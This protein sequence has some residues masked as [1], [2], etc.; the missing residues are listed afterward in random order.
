VAVAF[1][2]IVGLGILISGQEAPTQKTGLPDDWTHHHLVFSNPGTAAQALKEGRLEQWYK[3]TNDPRY[4]IQ[5]LKRNPLQRALAGAQDFAA[6]SAILNANAVP[7]RP[8]VSKNEPVKKDWNMDL[9]P[10]GTATLTA[11]VGTTID[12]ATLPSGSSFTIDGQTF[13][14]K[15]PTTASANG[16]FSGNPTNGQ[17]LQIKNV[18]PSITLTAST[19]TP[20]TQ[21][22]MFGAVPTEATAG[23]VIS[24]QNGANTL[25]VTNSASGANLPNSTWTN[26]PTTT[27][28]APSVTVS[29]VVTNLALA[30][31]AAAPTATATFSGPLAAGNTL[32]I[33]YGVTSLTLTAA[34]GSNSTAYVQVSGTVSNTYNIVVGAVTYAFAVASSCSGGTPSAPCIDI[35]TSTN[36]AQAQNI[37]AAINDNPNECSSTTGNPCFGDITAPNPEA[38]AGAPTNPFSTYWRIPLTNEYYQSVSFSKTGTNLGVSGSPMSQATTNGCSS[39]TL[40][41]FIIGTGQV[42]SAANLYNILTSSAACV[43]TYSV[44]VTVSGLSNNTFNVGETMYGAT[45]GVSNAFGTGAGGYTNFGWSN[46]TTGNVGSGNSCSGTTSPYTA[47][48]QAANTTAG[49]M[50][51]VV[52]AIQACP[53]GANIWAAPGTSNAFTVYNNTLAT[54]SSTISG[55]SSGTPSIV[56]WATHVSGS[57]GSNS[58]TGTTSAAFRVLST[59]TTAALVA[60]ELV[61]ALTGCATTNDGTIGIVTGSGT[62]HVANTGATVTITANQWAQNPGLALTSSPGGPFSWTASAITNGLNG[63]NTPPSFAVDNILNDDATNLAAAIAASGS[64][65]GVSA[66]TNGGAEVII[67]ASAAGL[68]GNSITLTN[69]LSSISFPTGLTGGSNGSDSSTTFAYWSG[70]TYDNQSQLA[71]DIYAAL[72]ANSTITGATGAFTVGA[73]NSPGAGDIVLTYKTAGSGGD[74][75][76]LISTFSALTGG[77]FTGGGGGS[78]PEIYPAKFS[79]SSTGT[80]VCN[81]V[82]PSDYVAYATAE[83]GSS[84]QATIIAYTNIYPGCTTVSGASAT[85][86]VVYW[87]YNTGPG[88]VLTSPVLYWDG[89]RIAFIESNAPAGSATLRILRWKGGDGTDYK[90]PVAP[91]NS[92]TNAAAGAGG[93]TSWA[94]CPSGASCMISVPFQAD[95]N[96]VSNSSPWY[97]YASDTLWV[98]DDGGYLHEFTQVFGGKPGEVTTTW[99]VAVSTGNVLTSPVYDNTHSLVFVC[100]KGGYLESV[101]TAGT[102]LT[103]AQ[104]GVAAVDI[105]EAPTVDPSAGTV[106]AFVSAHS[107]YGPSVY[108]F[109]Y[110]A[111]SGSSGNAHITYN[112]LGAPGSTVPLYA[113]DFDNAYYTSSDPPT[114]HM[115][116]C[117][118]TGANPIL[119]AL[120]ISGGNLS[121]SATTGPT[122][123]NS[124]TPCSPVTEFDNGTSDLIFVSPQLYTAPSPAVTGCTASQ[125][126]VI[127][128]TITNTPGYSEN[129][130]GPFPGGASGIIID[131]QSVPV[132]T[133]LQLYFGT[134]GTQSCGTSGNPGYGTG[135]CAVQASQAGP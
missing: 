37:E 23:D 97:D 6:R 77:S 120:T 19:G 38:A 115:W 53:A 89:S 75:Q 41:T 88:S 126:C 131:T 103:S 76:S 64:T 87:S 91:T 40:G 52:A 111:I 63:N 72:E 117:G 86:P 121:S 125:G 54:L 45:N 51:N 113:G 93:N 58:C 35:D 123:S 128:Y 94:S 80:G 127:S 101:S 32:T 112:S 98:G 70:S 7:H 30:S 82:S 104:I 109:T 34:N 46:Q 44:P 48:Y 39:A 5:Q 26:D 1:L 62:G 61:T 85:S 100:S 74:S 17:T 92:Y 29:G 116:I 11:V 22:G 110:N 84:S 13:T 28:T 124:S 132:S 21:T 78:A 130:A 83:N 118:D 16:T 20:G 102:V 68:S 106:Y 99:P 43:S 25:T 66:S 14:A 73:A 135:G 65:V 122:L 95:P 96:T 114:G 2:S 81:N 9:G 10:V 119:Y 50:A 47:H 108:Q 3:I 134:L 133:Q 69:G 24:I 90:S 15:D 8:P 42:G 107:T 57:A 31:G 55:S 60:A 71:S 59:D 105:A 18:T 49:L 36:Q 129:G 27:Q 4:Q 33:A 67:T 56:S 79:Y 12:A